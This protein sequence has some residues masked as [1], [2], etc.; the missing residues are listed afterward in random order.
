MTQDLGWKDNGL[1]QELDGTPLRACQ[2]LS[3]IRKRGCCW[4]TQG[5]AFR[6]GLSVL[7]PQGALIPG[8]PEEQEAGIGTKTLVFCMTGQRVL[9]LE[10]F[11]KYYI[12]GFPSIRGFVLTLHPSP[13]FLC[14]RR[15][16]Y[17]EFSSTWV[18]AWMWVLRFVHL[19]TV[20]ASSAWLSRSLAA[21]GSETCKGS[22][23]E[24]PFSLWCLR[25]VAAVREGKIVNSR[26]LKLCIETLSLFNQTFYHKVL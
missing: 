24:N 3:L 12:F 1:A 18:E 26:F 25:S 4:M 9:T 23:N 5:T 19:I 2:S 7:L 8:Q 11:Y 22:P 17:K 13:F 14:Q 16:V 6:Q 20:N 15:W 21:W 10:S